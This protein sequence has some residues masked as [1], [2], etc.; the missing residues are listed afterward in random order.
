MGKVNKMLSYVDH[1]S[2]RSVH[3]QAHKNVIVDALNT[4]LAECRG[5]F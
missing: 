5:I 1:Q 2:L 4:E 3:I